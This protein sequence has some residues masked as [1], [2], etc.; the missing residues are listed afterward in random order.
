L[1]VINEIVL[2]ALGLDTVRPMIYGLI[3]IAS[4]LFLPDGLESLVPRLRALLRRRQKER[5]EVRPEIRP[6]IRSPGARSSLEET[7]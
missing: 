1:T 4:V 3:L 6:E 7:S 2:R 5:S